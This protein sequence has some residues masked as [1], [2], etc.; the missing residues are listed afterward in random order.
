MVLIP[1]VTVVVSA[2]LHGER[3]TPAFA[4]G[5]VLVLA[6]VYIGAIRRPLPAAVP[7][8]RVGDETIGPT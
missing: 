4:V 1:L 7:T 3:I 5:S 6:G 2:W 8:G